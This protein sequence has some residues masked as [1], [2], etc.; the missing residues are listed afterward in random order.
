MPVYVAMLR[1]I[2]VGG[3]NLIKMEGLRAAFAALGFD[4][5][6]TYVQSGNIVFQTATTA[7]ARLAK[8]TSKKILDAFGLDVPVL[9]R[10]ADEL[11]E[12]L[13]S[14]PLLKR[15]G[16]DETKLHV[17][18]LAA[19]SPKQTDEILKPLAGQSE[20]FAVRGTE[21][22]LYCPG[23]Y[24]STKLSNGAI[25]KK[26]SVHATTRNWNTVNVLTA[27]AGQ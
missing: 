21:I 23:G 19:A 6:R 18:F 24:G 9:I 16:I 17:T 13:K 8:K 14:N 12:V 1:G 15:T 7:T 3:H 4:D 5:V 26:L 25:E 27:M 2:N 22:Y 20:L 11:S 10:T